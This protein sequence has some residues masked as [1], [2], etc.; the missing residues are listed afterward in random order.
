MLVVYTIGHSTRRLEEL[1][2]ILKNFK[3]EV[4]VDIRHFPHSKHNPQF[5]KEVLERELIKENIEYIWLEKLGGFRRGGYLEFTKTGE[6][7]EGLEELIKIVKNK[8]TAIMCAEILWFKC[9]RRF[10]SDE[11]K[12]IGF[13]VFHIYNKNKIQDHSLKENKIKCD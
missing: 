12:K 6:F 10:V 9:H 1:I 7:K 5:N 11:L 4:L 3:I 2:G 8:L 13:E